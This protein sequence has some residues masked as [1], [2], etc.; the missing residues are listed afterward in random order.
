MIN[1]FSAFDIFDIGLTIVKVA[2]AAIITATILHQI[3][4]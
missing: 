4:A 3:I 2:I 1:P